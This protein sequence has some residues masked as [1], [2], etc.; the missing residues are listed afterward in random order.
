MVKWIMLENQTDWWQD[1][2]IN[3]DLSIFVNGGKEPAPN[4]TWCQSPF[5]P[6]EEY[7]LPEL[8]EKCTFHLVMLCKIVNDVI[9][10]TPLGCII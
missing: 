5:H 3:M 10:C 4:L 7:L 6:Q 1:L 9:L 2:F 8:A